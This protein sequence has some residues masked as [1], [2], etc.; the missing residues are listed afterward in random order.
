MKITLIWDKWTFGNTQPS[1]F[2]SVNV[3]L[4]LHGVGG[5]EG[6]K[7][8]E[9]KNRLWS[10]IGYQV[11]LMEYEIWLVI[12]S[13]LHWR[14]DDLAYKIYIHTKDFLLDCNQSLSMSWKR[15]SLL[16]LIKWEIM[17]ALSWENLMNKVQAN[18]SWLSS[19]NCLR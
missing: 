19:E 5:R 1:R 13:S 11:T 16:V 2:P 3:T 7:C 15:E 10:L 4:T 14:I 9:F 18:I 8:Q 6:E 12:L 17:R